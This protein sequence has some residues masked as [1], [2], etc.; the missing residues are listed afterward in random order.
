MFHFVW[1]FL[2]VGNFWRSGIFVGREFLS[3]FFGV[4]VARKFLGVFGI[5]VG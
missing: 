5:F 3:G 4:F 1:G 2:F